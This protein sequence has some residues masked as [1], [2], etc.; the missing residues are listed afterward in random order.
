MKRENEYNLRLYGNLLKSY[1]DKERN[2]ILANIVNKKGYIPDLTLVI[3]SNKQINDT[4]P[5]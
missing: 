2:Y 3:R 5:D 4:S 1:P